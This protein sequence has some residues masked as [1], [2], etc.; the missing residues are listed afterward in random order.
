MGLR[1]AG[2]IAT[3]LIDHGDDPHRPVAIVAEGTRDAHGALG[4]TLATLPYASRSVPADMPALLV[5]GDVVGL[6]LGLAW[7]GG[8]NAPSDEIAGRRLAV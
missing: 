3:T 4:C 1:N 2:R 6:A 7:F 5:I 8:D